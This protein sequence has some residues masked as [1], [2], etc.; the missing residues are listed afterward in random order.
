MIF[1]KDK[2][3][4]VVAVLDWHKKTFP[5]TTEAE[6]I[7]KVEEEY[8]EYMECLIDTKLRKYAMEEKADLIISLIALA[9]RYN[10]NLAEIALSGKFNK[11]SIPAV[12][13]KLEM[14]KKRKWKN[15]HHI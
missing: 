15:N 2:N 3:D 11:S 9:Y 8:N 6:Q 12:H 4:V 13:K 10:N 1:G 7:L 14:N 5:N